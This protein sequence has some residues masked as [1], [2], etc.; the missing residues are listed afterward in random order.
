MT[1][2][3]IAAEHGLRLCSSACDLAAT[4]AIDHEKGWPAYNDVIH[5]R[6]RRVTRRG[7]YRFLKLVVV[8][9]MGLQ[10]MRGGPERTWLM[11]TGSFDL[12]LSLGI[13]FSR[14][15]LADDRALVRS[16]MATGWGQNMDDETRRKV[17]RW[18]RS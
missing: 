15:I 7:L 11:A 5:W 8:A 3:E 6:D 10:Q 12:A 16:W 1:Y 9:K 14:E 2:P 17:A 4:L 18:A 13:R